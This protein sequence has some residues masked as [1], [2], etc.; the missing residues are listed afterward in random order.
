MTLSSD[1]TVQS[2]TCGGPLRLAET[3]D[4]SEPVLGQCSGPGAAAA[5]LV[6]IPAPSPEG[7]ARCCS[8]GC[9]GIGLGKPGLGTPGAVRVDGV[10]NEYGSRGRRRWVGGFIIIIIFK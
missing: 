1:G 4:D 3:P 10:G 7:R 2:E 9:E 5:G 6:V 8:P